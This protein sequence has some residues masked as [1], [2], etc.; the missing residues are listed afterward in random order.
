M[1]YYQG[2]MVKN[3]KIKS[4]FAGHLTFNFIVGLA[5]I[6]IVLFFGTYGYHVFE[7]MAWVDSFANAAM[8]LSGMGPLGPLNT[9]GGKIFAG[10]YAIFCGLAFIA[11]VALIFAP[12]VHRFFVKV[13]LENSSSTNKK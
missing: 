7:K 5:F 2:Y 1:S 3:F 9:D 13:H 8:I 6:I 11:I 4:T 10:C 12:I